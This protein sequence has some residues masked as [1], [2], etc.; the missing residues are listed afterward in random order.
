[1]K[2][3]CAFALIVTSIIAL[4]SIS[5]FAA[6]ALPVDHFSI[7]GGIDPEKTCDI[8]FDSTRLISGTAPK[9]TTVT[10]SVYDVTNPEYKQLDNSY[11]LTVGSAGIFSQSINLAEGRNYVVVTAVNGDKRSEVTTTI[12]R[13]GR[14]IKAVLSQYIAL[15]GQ[16]K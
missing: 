2:R 14:V 4:H 3:F 1:M 13:K 16:N 11:S 12:N 8:T 5:A 10:I 9:D 7:T 15:P 6:E